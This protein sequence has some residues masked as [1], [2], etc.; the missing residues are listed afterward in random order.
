MAEEYCLEEHS[1]E[2]KFVVAGVVG[3]RVGP[4]GHREGGLMNIGLIAQECNQS[5]YESG[6]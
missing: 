1:S 3:F 6:G 5:D 4:G 2:D